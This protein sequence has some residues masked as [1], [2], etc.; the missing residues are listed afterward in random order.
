MGTW[1]FDF[2]RLLENLSLAYIA[3]FIFFLVIDYFPK[4]KQSKA[5][6]TVVSGDLVNLYLYMSTIISVYKHFCSIAKEDKEINLSDLS[7]LPQL[8][9]NENVY[10]YKTTAIINGVEKETCVDN[11]NLQYDSTKYGKLIQNTLDK[12]SLLPCTVYLAPKLLT[13]LSEIKAN[14]FLSALISFEDDPFIKNKI[15]VEHMS[16]DKYFLDFIHG[17]EALKKYNFSKYDYK[18]TEISDKELQ[19]N[20]MEQAKQIQKNPELLKILQILNTKGDSKRFQKPRRYSSL[21]SCSFE[22]ISE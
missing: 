20:L 18:T 19:Q 7:E 16:Y 3:S 1:G 11:F 5:A 17:H 2:W 22:S 8:Q 14:N 10:H 9:I 15:S 13:T 6:F 21:S 4:K 12:I